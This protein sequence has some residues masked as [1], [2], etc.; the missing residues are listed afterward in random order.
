M[1]L[2]SLA[3]VFVSSVFQ[4]VINSFVLY[5]FTTV[6]LVNIARNVPMYIFLALLVLPLPLSLPSL[7][8]IL[9]AIVVVVVITVFFSY[10]SIVVVLH[11]RIND[12][13]YNNNNCI[14]RPL[15]LS[16]NS[17]AIIKISQSV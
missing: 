15:S 11:I 8:L 13:N 9:L 7:L 12:C 6:T 4:L 2:F 16:R 17:V 3:F 10:L 5:F 1:F 14:L